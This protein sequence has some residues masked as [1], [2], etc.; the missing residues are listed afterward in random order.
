[1]PFLYWLSKLCLS[2]KFSIK[3]EILLIS[4][5]KIWES[6]IQVYKSKYAQTQTIKHSQI[7]PKFYGL[8]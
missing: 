2:K 3:F 1:M 6:F 4:E 7:Y 8:C 5:K